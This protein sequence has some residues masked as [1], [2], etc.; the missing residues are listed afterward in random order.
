[1]FEIEHLINN[2]L[3]NYN[4]VCYKYGHKHD[5]IINENDKKYHSNYIFIGSEFPLPEDLEDSKRN[6]NSIEKLILLSFNRV[7]NNL[8]TI[9]GIIKEE[10]KSLT[11]NIY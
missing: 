3:K 5:K 10:M 7:R 4:S 8:L 9:R 6:A 2:N 1:M 11:P